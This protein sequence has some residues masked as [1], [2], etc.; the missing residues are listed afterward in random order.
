MCFI[1]AYMSTDTLLGIS[2][3]DNRYLLTN[4]PSLSSKAHY[5]LRWLLQHHARS[6]TNA[7]NLTALDKIA[8]QALGQVTLKR[9][10]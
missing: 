3:F 10:P 9:R 6:K 8:A 1:Y 2:L 4:Q 7:L 5:E